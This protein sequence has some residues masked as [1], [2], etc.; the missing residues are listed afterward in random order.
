[1]KSFP[2]FPHPL[3]CNIEKPD[4]KKKSTKETKG[5]IVKEKY[6]SAKV[7]VVSYKDFSNAGCILLQDFLNLSPNELF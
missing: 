2:V 7:Y 5:A 6:P 3:N 4:V 1:M